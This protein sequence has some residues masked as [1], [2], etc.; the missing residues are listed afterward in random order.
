[1]RINGGSAEQSRELRAYFLKLFNYYGPQHWWPGD[2]PFEI[3]VGAILTQ[4]T[5]WRNVEKALHKLKQA[6]AIAPATLHRLPI[7]RLAELIRPSGYYNLKAR[8]L[9]AFTKFL[10]HEYDGDLNQMFRVKEHLAACVNI[11]PKVES[12]FFWEGKTCRER[13][14]LMVVKT[15]LRRFEKMAKR[16]RQ[17]HPYSVPEIIALPIRK[18]FTDYLDWIEDMTR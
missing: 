8:R 4:N 2:T 3:A 11:V 15:T 9:K 16:V 5:A 18:G 12:I 17:M 6:D 10:F 14:S 1:M 7:R 13:E